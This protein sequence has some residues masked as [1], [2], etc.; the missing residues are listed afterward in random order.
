[1]DSNR[2]EIGSLMY[3]K[4]KLR[5]KYEELVNLVT[6]TDS[7]YKEG[8]LT[9]KGNFSAKEIKKLVGDL[10]VCVEEYR[11]YNI[12][13]EMGASVQMEK[14]TLPERERDFYEALFYVS[15]G[16]ALVNEDG[17]DGWWYASGTWDAAIERVQR[18]R[19][20][21][22]SKAEFHRDVIARSEL[23]YIIPGMQWRSPEGLFEAL[24]VAY[25][26]VTGKYLSELL[27][28]AERKAA[29]KLLTKEERK[30]LEM[31]EKDPGTLQR[32]ENEERDYLNS[33]E[34]DPV[35][36]PEWEGLTPEEISSLYDDDDEMPPYWK[37]EDEGL[38]SL[39]FAD[40]TRFSDACRILLADYFDITGEADVEDEFQ[41]AVHLYL[42][43]NGISSWLDDERFFPVFTYLSKACKASRKS[44]GGES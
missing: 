24:V 15:L 29:I 27:T 13:V 31:E 28:D 33:I 1:M 25:G 36:V 35:D 21:Y 16:I 23:N 26:H 3:R 10:V 2:T 18:W 14:Y 17:P 42:A 38:W 12:A 5:E 40:T 37:E 11:S 32:L 30:N 34:L 8:L 20:V 4:R 6:S 7:G 19:P 39:Y 41:N 43:K 9:K 22:R 44:L